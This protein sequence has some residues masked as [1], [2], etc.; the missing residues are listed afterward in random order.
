MPDKGNTAPSFNNRFFLYGRVSKSLLCSLV[1]SEEKVP[2][3][4][5]FVAFLIDLPGFEVEHQ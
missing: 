4:S 5:H 1:L 3:K 2:S